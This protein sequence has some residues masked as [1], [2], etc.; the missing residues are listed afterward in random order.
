MFGATQRRPSYHPAYR[1]AVTRVVDPRRAVQ[2]M[3]SGLQCRG[4][5]LPPDPSPRTL[6]PDVRR[7]WDAVVHN[8]GGYYRDQQIAEVTAW[9]A[10]RMFY[11]PNGARVPLLD[12]RT[13]PSSPLGDPGE[14]TQ[15]GV[16]VEYTFIDALARLQIKKFPKNDAPFLFW[17][18]SLRTCYAFPGAEL[19]A[20]QVPDLLS[21]AS[22][23]YKTW[24][25]REPRCERDVDVPETSITLEGFCDTIVYASDKWHEPD[26]SIRMTASGEYIHQVGDGV[27]L[28]QAPGKVP[29][30]VAIT[31]GCFDLEARGLIH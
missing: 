7:F 26:P 25:Q 20:C 23:T 6:P 19:G 2:I 9:K 13:R 22:A 17:S 29:L 27:G 11:A 24:T 18:A 30:A 12:E 5:H 14:L 4:I 15:L 16:L 1:A 28:W 3:G 21:T 31:G 10:V 8:A